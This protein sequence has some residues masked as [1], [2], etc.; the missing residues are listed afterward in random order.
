ME[1]VRTKEKYIKKDKIKQEREVDSLHHSH[2]SS[3]YPS[4]RST[5]SRA[6]F[7]VEL[8]SQSIFLL[9]SSSRALPL[10]AML[11]KNKKKKNTREA[12]MKRN[13]IKIRKTLNKEK[14]NKQRNTEVYDIVCCKNRASSSTSCFWL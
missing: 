6:L 8:P 4:S 3:L 14:Q 1:R 5:L 9:S 13:K 10:E 2:S 12:S 7:L 11:M